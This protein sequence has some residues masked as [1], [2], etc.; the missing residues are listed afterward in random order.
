MLS[1]EVMVVVFEVCNATK[2]AT[3]HPWVAK[4][5]VL[6]QLGKQTTIK[7]IYQLLVRACLTQERTKSSLDLF[8]AT[9]CGK[10]CGQGHAQNAKNK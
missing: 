1:T 8:E 4:R 2:A 6:L 10:Y 3:A 9:G 7:Q 5:M